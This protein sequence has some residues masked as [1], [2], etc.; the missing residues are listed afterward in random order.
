MHISLNSLINTFNRKIKRKE[1]NLFLVLQRSLL[2]LISRIGSSVVFLGQLGLGRGGTVGLCG[3]LGGVGG[4]A[5]GLDLG[6]L[7]LQ[8]GDL[9]LSLLDV[10]FGVLASSFSINSTSNA[11][12]GK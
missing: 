12:V 9:L 5:V 4:T 10:L 1:S 6:L 2:Q 3:L 11:G 8:A 7:L